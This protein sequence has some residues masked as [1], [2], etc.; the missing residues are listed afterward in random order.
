M[1]S[2]QV[3]AAW[4]KSDRES[5]GWLSLVRHCEDAAEVAG[6]L[7]DE[8]LPRSTRRFLAGG[9]TDDVARILGRFLAGTHDV[10][11]LSPA[12]AIQVDMLCGPMRDAGLRFPFPIDHR[13][14]APHS[15]VGFI[16]LQ[17]YLQ[18]VGFNRRTARSYAVVGGSHHGVPPTTSQAVAGAERREKHFGDAQ[19][20]A[21]RDEL[22][23]HVIEHVD[24]QSLL[25]RWASTPLTRPQQV[26]WT[27]FVIM[28]DW[29]ASN[30]HLFSLSERTESVVAAADAWR[31][32]DLPAPWFADPPDDLGDLMTD[33]FELP[34]GAVPNAMQGAVVDAARAM[35]E[36]GML[37][38]E[39]T[40][41][42]GKTEA[43]FAAAE[44]LAAKFGLGGVFVALPT[45][46]TSD[47][48][49]TRVHTW[50]SN[51]GSEVVT[52]V[53]LAHSKSHLNDE[54]RGLDRTSRLVDIGT[55]SDG[56]PT[57]CTAEV[58]AHQWFF[59][60]KR[61]MLADVVVGTIDQLLFAGLQA[62]HVMLRHL[63]L[64]NKVMVIDE[65]HA[66]D[67]YMRH[68]LIRSLEWLAAY[69][70]P[71]IMMS[72]TLPGDQ[73]V[74]LARAYESGL[75]GAS[76]GGD[77]IGGDLGYPVVTSVGVTRSI[78]TVP[79]ETLTSVTIERRD[80]EDATL[81]ALL[82][83]A[84]A[85][86]GCV[87]VIRNTVRRAQRTAGVLRAEFGDDVVL[88][89]SRFVAKHRSD[90]EKELVGQLGREGR[91]PKM[92]IVV[93][94]QVIEQSLDLD[95]DLLISDIAP[96]DLLLQRVGRLHRH[97]RERPAALQ[98]PRLVLTGVLDWHAEPPT[99]DTG[100][101]RVYGASRLYRCAAV[102]DGRETIT[103]PADVPKLVQ[104]AYAE[105]VAAADAWTATM[106]A[107]DRQQAARAADQRDR[108]ETW[109][110]S[111]PS[112]RD[113]IDWFTKNT[114]DADDPRGYARVRDS[115]E[116]I[117]VLLTRSVGGVVYLLP[118][119]GGD[120]ID[121][122]FEPPS[123]LARKALNSSIRLPI[124]LSRPDKI[125]RTITELELRMYEGWQSS[126][127]LAG[128][129]VVELDESNSA[130]VLDYRVTY[131]ENDGLLVD[132]IETQ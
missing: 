32:L 38:I 47:A 13:S 54:F 75:G 58:I 8:W 131:D 65:V 101:T 72:A 11:K 23:A 41:G 126:K 98:K 121:T 105:Q 78:S 92:R 36:P 63:A 3:L 17:G 91:R 94:T 73:R 57:G 115:D 74:A 68:Y 67:E 84:M 129:L 104:A 2:R 37:I 62:K 33:R 123:R 46:A 40:M 116:C 100:A 118:Q 20:A 96:V 66:A 10:G 56:T 108:A 122:H 42:S 28:A 5:D 7:W 102:L 99:L 132:R 86:G 19:W 48:M 15:L 64:A 89:H 81:V 1:L 30:G 77:D 39:S 128:E 76:A 53:M 31:E 120:L 69:R 112:G 83:D 80:D 127:W 43:A 79:Q 34:P 60:R 87:A 55:D 106:V 125:D 29:I 109:R 114:L 26:L 18:S 50:L 16:A 88:L 51:Q 97:R 35:T 103:L 21:A 124:E 22:I 113:L 93:A 12:F 45:M 25:E 27:G 70:I 82:R 59:G 24:A 49:F 71:V 111:A 9:S 107:A 52:S 44:Y 14:D 61:S 110:L 119:C 95:F 6:Y 117:E 4:A 130:E 90:L 85:G